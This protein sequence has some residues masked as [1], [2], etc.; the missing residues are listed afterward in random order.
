[1][2]AMSLTA[3]Y[4][5]S[6]QSVNRSQQLQVKTTEIVACGSILLKTRLNSVCPRAEMDAG[7]L[8]FKLLFHS[9]NIL[10]PFSVGHSF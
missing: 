6:Q 7:R 3:G 5:H 9:S 1:M 2:M 8:P 10:M 4:L